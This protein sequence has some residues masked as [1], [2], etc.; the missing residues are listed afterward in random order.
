MVWATDSNAFVCSTVLP[1]G[2]SAVE[3]GDLSTNGYYAAAIP[4]VQLQIAKAGYRLVLLLLS[5]P[6]PSLYAEIRWAQLID[7][8]RLAAWL[9]L[10]ATGTTALEKNWIGIGKVNPSKGKEWTMGKEKEWS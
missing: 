4:V 5:F 7:V 10:I 6:Y 2:V 8:N 9:D 1:N 3:A